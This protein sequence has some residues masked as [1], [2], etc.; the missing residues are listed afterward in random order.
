MGL[1]HAPS[2]TRALTPAPA[3][4]RLQVRRLIP[5]PTVKQNFGALLAGQSPDRRKLAQLVDLL[6]RM[7]QVGAGRSAHGCCLAVMWVLW[8]VMRGA[9]Q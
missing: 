7:M 1:L 3:L 6:E 4:P 2:N 8:R 5:N 9:G